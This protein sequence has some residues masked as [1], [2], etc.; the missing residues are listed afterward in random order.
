ME[1]KADITVKLWMVLSTDA[2]DGVFRSGRL[3]MDR[4]VL[5]ETTV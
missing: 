5:A 3:A 4:E 1:E 2:L